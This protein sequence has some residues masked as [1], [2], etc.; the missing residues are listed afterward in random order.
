MISIITF[1]VCIILVFI[2]WYHS[3]YWTFFQNVENISRF[4]STR[5]KI[6]APWILLQ[7][8]N[9]TNDQC[10]LYIETIQFFH[11]ANQLTGFYTMEKLVFNELMI[12]ADTFLFN[13]F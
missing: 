7:K 3:K 2:I 8:R 6:K 5:W 10:P 12:N 9:P 11:Y 13:P 4:H 1:L